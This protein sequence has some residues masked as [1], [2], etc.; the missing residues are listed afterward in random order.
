MLKVGFGIGRIDKLPRNKAVR[1]L[2][3]QFVSLFDGAPHALAAVGEH[4]FGTVCLHDLAAFYG[5]GFRH[6][7]DKPVAACCRHR[8]KSDSRI[9]RGRLNDDGSGLQQSLFLGIVDHGF[10]DAVL[11]G[12]RRIEVLQLGKNPGVQTQLF[13]DMGKLQQWRFADQLIGGSVNGRHSVFPP[14]QFAK[15]YIPTNTVCRY[16][17][18]F[19]A[20]CQ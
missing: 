14:L 12:S 7:D 20:V 11:Y 4:Q 15:P 5:H 1:D 8:C 13:L 10:G 6:D 16:Y 17:R 2:L 9:A 18:P 19:R 3:C